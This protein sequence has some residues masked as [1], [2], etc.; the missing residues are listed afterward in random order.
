MVIRGCVLC[1]HRAQKQGEV[2]LGCVSEDG[3]AALEGWAVVSI[4]IIF[5]LPQ[6]FQDLPWGLVEP[7][8]VVTTVNGVTSDSTGEGRV[9]KVLSG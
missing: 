9:L 5:Y 7:S 6:P 1:G 3:D 8:P 4:T 2:V